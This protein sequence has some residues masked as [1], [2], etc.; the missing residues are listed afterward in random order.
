MRHPCS[1]TRRCR[2]ALMRLDYSPMSDT[3]AEIRRPLSHPGHRHRRSH[4]RVLPGARA[5]PRARGRRRSTIPSLQRLLPAVL[6]HRPRPGTR[7]RRRSGRAHATPRGPWWSSPAKQHD[8][9]RDRAASPACCYERLDELGLDF[10]VVY[11]SLGL[12]FL[13]TGDDDVPARRVPRA[14]PL[15]RRDLRA[16]RRPPRARRRDPD[17]H[18]RRG[19]RRARVRGRTCSASS[20]CCAPATCSARST[21]SPASRSR[22]RAVRDRGSTSSASTPRTTTTRC[23]RRRRSSASRSRSTRA[24]SG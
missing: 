16:V 4:R 7:R 20:R 22:A 14:Q 8:R 23:G 17:A 15:Q 24:S 21:R 3:S 9:P 2:R 10:S 1:P 11:P 5:V 19:R 12:V 18:A 13:H 6:G